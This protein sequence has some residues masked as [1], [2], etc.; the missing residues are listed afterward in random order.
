MELC[1][2]LKPAK[3]ASLRDIIRILV[4]TIQTEMTDI[5]IVFLIYV[6]ICS[7]KKYVTNFFFNFFT[8]NST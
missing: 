5:Q 3:H 6:N 8:G 7:K 2:R 1:R 4:R